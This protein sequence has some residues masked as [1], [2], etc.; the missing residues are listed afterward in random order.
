MFLDRKRTFILL[1][2][3]AIAVSSSFYHSKVSSPIK[4]KDFV[5]FQP[6]EVFSHL[7]NR[8][9]SIGD[10]TFDEW[11]KEYGEW[12]NL[13]VNVFFKRTAVYYF[14]DTNM[15]HM[16]MLVKSGIKTIN[17]SLNVKVID[18]KSSFREKVTNLVLNSKA[19]SVNLVFVIGEYNYTS[20][21][22]KVDFS[23]LNIDIK[24]Q[25]SIRIQIMVEDQSTKNKTDQPLE[26]KIKNMTN[27]YTQ[28]KGSM[29][30]TKC[31]H[32]T[33]SKHYLS[34]RWFIELNR[35]IGYEK[36][37][38]CNHSIENHPSFD[39]LFR[40]NQ[41]YVQLA[42]LKCLPNLQHSVKRF[43]NFTYLK[44]YQQ[45]VFNDV[46][47]DEIKYG[48]IMILVMNECYLD[49]IDKYKRVTI[50]DNDETILPLK[51]SNFFRADE[52]A[53]YISSLKESSISKNDVFG[54]I[55]C[56]RYD[57]NIN[58]EE[59][60]SI[61]SY[62]NELMFNEKVNRPKSIHFQQGFQIYHSL[63]DK[64]IESVADTIK[65]EYQINNSNINYTVQVLDLNVKKEM[66]ISMEFT[67]KGQDQLNYAKNMVKIYKEIIKPY[68]EANK[69]FISANVKDFDRFFVMISK[70]N[71]RFCGKTVHDTRVSF[72]LT[73]H[74]MEHYINKT[75][76][77]F[78]RKLLW[79]QQFWP[80]INEART[81]H[82]RNNLGYFSDLYKQ[83]PIV[84]FQLDLNY[85]NCYFIPILERL[86]NR[87]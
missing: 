57:S 23:S 65:R 30:C 82:F 5:E 40:D 27:S 83:V 36:I 24:E 45:I 75:Q 85:L 59:Q 66:N 87:I 22:A 21:S 63:V 68:F 13:G 28:K 49:N 20:L 47:H 3:T 80:S 55:K 17:Y 34:L 31:Y 67:I 4:L 53:N 76:V 32:F 26:A 19:I 69:N 11:C 1:A 9:L 62:F 78:D 38:M 18:K 43:E 81:S 70:H 2:L 73:I 71:S 39:K 64:I 35:E 72:D 50:I 44:R 61:E 15:F 58:V 60:T 14:M 86:K 48:V 33:E 10:L 12:E 54:N 37:F 51:T 84:D 56:N 41:D 29:I 79:Q 25:D 52:S 42:Q 6:V 16:L 46:I 74:Y 7:K 8:Q 77:V